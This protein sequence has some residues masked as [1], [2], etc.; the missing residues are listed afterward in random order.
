MPDTIAFPPLQRP[1]AE[2]PLAGLTVLVVEDSRYACEAMRLLCQHSGARLRRADSLAA[3]ARHLRVYR[4]DVLIVDL[5]LPDGPGEA[6]IADLVQH[7]ARPAVILGTSGDPLLAP[8][9]L[10]AGADGFLDKPLP[11]LAGFQA[12]LLAYLPEQARLVGPVEEPREEPSL[13]PDPIALRD[14]LALAEDILASGPD[15]PAGD[16]VS[17]FLSGL[18]RSAHDRQLEHAAVRLAHDLRAERGAATGPPA[19]RR[20]AALRRVAGLLRDRLAAGAPL[21][22][23]SSHSGSGP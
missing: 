7:S 9:A 6:L 15:G 5:G 23:E 19:T 16:Y 21:W 13:A 17:R 12:A 22:T 2:H 20:E 18:A 11:G 14:D 1:T 10:A 4:P 3:A 8:A